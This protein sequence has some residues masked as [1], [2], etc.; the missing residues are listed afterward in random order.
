M[1]TE[2]SSLGGLG[3]LASASPWGA[4]ANAAAQIAATPNTS[5]SGDIATGKKI[6]EGVSFGFSPG[7]MPWYAWAAIAGVALVFIL[8]RK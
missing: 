1:A 2:K 8:R 4:V 5:A 7:R 3:G 6:F